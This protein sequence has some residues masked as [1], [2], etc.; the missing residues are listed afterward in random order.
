MPMRSLGFVAWL[1]SSLIVGGCGASV[2]PLPATVPAEDPRP[3]PD[4][5][6]E[7]TP[8]APPDPKPGGPLE[9]S[10]GTCTIPGRDA[11]EAEC[12][13]VDVPARRG[14]AG[15]TATTPV[16][17]YRLKAGRQP[18]AA[19]MW[20]LNGGPGGAG[21]SLAPF[22]EMVNQVRT[23]DIDA[24]LVDHRGTGS[25]NFLDCPRTLRTARTTKDFAVKCSAEIREKFG[26]LVDGY[27]TTES[28]HDVR[29]LIDSTAT[30][31]Q[32]VFVYG[33]S[34][35]SYWAH[36]LLQL[37]GV[38]VDAVVTDGNCLGP[39]CNFDVPQHL[40]V[41]EPMR[42]LADLCKETPECGARL[43][44]DPWAFAAATFEKIAGGHCA[45]ARFAQWSAA[46]LVHSIGVFW[47]AG[48]APTIYRLDRCEPRDVT[49]LNAFEQRLRSFSNDRAPMPLPSI[50]P[51]PTPKST[52][53]SS[54]TLQAHVIASEMISQPPPSTAS[55]RALAETK[56]FKAD[57]DRLDLSYFADWRGYPRDEFVGGWVERDVPW[58]V[59]QGTFDFQ[60]VH[61]WTAKA[62]A[63]VKDP[64][65]QVVTVDGGG[66]GVVFA[67]ECS[68][69][70]LESFLAD[71]RAKVD[72]GCLASVRSSALVSNPRYV[73]YF[74]G[75]R[76]AWD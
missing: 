39:V 72:T 37:P 40:M 71:P 30:P 76:N 13:T 29:E 26:D 69:E 73:E 11:I 3:T 54:S 74:F 19:Q 42:H 36:R 24:Y 56:T 41:D 66:H 10:W 7:A 34:Y 18:A 46:S 33:G 52:Q 17:I 21:W 45:E 63:N 57:L 67:S 28:A 53:N 22:A 65:L 44:E 75:T 61:S 12:A 16:A 2:D 31:G 47:P 27:S 6:P 62:V 51:V 15:V 68:F 55:L 50:G 8:D 9:I 5:G 60:T 35:G 20:L 23:I 1:A 49:V 4:A 38:R 43:G 32:K 48:I 58:L 14:V 59:M 64:S 25:S 70:I